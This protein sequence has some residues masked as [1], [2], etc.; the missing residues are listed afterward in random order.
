MKI[1]FEKAPHPWQNLKG[2]TPFRL[3]E[4]ND[5]EKYEEWSDRQ[6]VYMLVSENG[7]AFIG[8]T[9][10]GTKEK[11]LSD[12]LCGLGY[13]SNP[14]HDKLAQKGVSVKDCLVYVMEIPDPEDR[15]EAKMVGIDRY[16][17]IGN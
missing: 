14:T 12:R 4:I 3:Q 13:R 5:A 7:A 16:Q 6:G 15:K 17:P 11:G 8:M 1:S 2:F 10:D 9:R